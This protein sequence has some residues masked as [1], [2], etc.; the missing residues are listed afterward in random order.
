MATGRTSSTDASN[1]NNLVNNCKVSPFKATD[2]SYI[3]TNISPEG[4]VRV[5][6]LFF[7]VPC[8][9]LGGNRPLVHS[10]LWIHHLRRPHMHKES[11][12][13]EKTLYSHSGEG[14]PMQ[15]VT[16][17]TTRGNRCTIKHNR[18]GA[19]FRTWLRFQ[20]R[21]ESSNLQDWWIKSN[22]RMGLVRFTNQMAIRFQRKFRIR[23]QNTDG[24][25]QTMNNYRGKRPKIS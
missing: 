25:K 15:E 20:V 4:L 19:V 21:F 16:D 23:S 18:G 24:S 9:I 11:K 1:G 12:N 8:D 13:A 22:P 6:N 2:S 5:A 7:P 14:W 10:V 17:Y 3:L